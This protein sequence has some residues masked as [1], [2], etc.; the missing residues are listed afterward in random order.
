MNRSDRS[1][2]P[3]DSREADARLLDRAGKIG[4]PVL[5]KA[6]SGGGGKGMRRIDR[7]AEFAGAAAA[8]RREAFAAFGD[9]RLLLEKLVEPAHHV[10]IQ[11]FADAHDHVIHLGERECSIQRRHQKIIEESPSPTIDAKLRAQMAEAAVMLAQ[12]AGYRSAGTCEFLVDESDHFHFLEVNARLQVEHPV[13][14][15]VVHEDLV[16][17]QVL[18]AAGEPLPFTQESLVQNGH[19]LECRVYAEDPSRGFLP[20]VGTLRHYAAPAGP[21]VRV[22]AGVERGSEVSVYYDPLLAKLIVHGKDRAEALR[23]MSWALRRFVI[24]GAT[25]NLEFLQALIVHPEFAAG[26]LHTG[27]LAEHS[28]SPP[29]DPLPE[30]AIFVAALAAGRPGRSARAADDERAEEANP[31]RTVGAW[32]A[33]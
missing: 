10:E 27:F 7:A 18:V 26:R 19:A 2:E 21:G 30:E 33:F 14:E 6:A 8:A 13:T 3:K 25:T 24:L 11:V 28:I 31:W 4:F 5:L 16:K 32:R 20:S 1:A 12:A 17:A 23:K 22:D 9:S 29:A 15:F